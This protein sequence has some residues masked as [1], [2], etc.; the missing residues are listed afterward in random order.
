MGLPPKGVFSCGKANKGGIAIT[1]G[2]GGMGR[3]ETEGMELLEMIEMD[4]R[5]ECR[6]TGS[7][8]S[9]IQLRRRRQARARAGGTTPRP[10]L[11]VQL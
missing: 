3:E 1:V 5:G 10:R 4:L 2:P 9:F 7:A 6:A 8:S 11:P